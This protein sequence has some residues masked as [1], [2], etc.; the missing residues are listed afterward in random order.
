MSRSYGYT[1]ENYVIPTGG[2]SAHAFRELQA[3]IFTFVKKWDKKDC[4]T[5][6]AY[7]GHGE[8]VQGTAQH[9]ATYEI[10]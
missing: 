3:R 10:A 4:L 6:Y 8:Y 2:G 5:I 9:V 7:S 1:V